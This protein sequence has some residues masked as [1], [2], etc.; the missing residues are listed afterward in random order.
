MAPQEGN[1]DDY[2]IL[3]ELDGHGIFVKFFQDLIR[4]LVAIP[5]QYPMMTIILQ[6]ATEFL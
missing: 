2:Q 4:I 6:E 3:Q 5:T 1:S